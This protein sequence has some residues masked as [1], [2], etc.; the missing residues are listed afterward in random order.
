MFNKDDFLCIKRG[1]YIEKELDINTP[2]YRY[3]SYLNFLLLLANNL[4]IPL[5]KCFED[6]LEKNSFFNIFLSDLHPTD[7]LISKKEQEQSAYLHNKLQNAINTMYTSCWT[8]ETQEN[9]LMWKSYTP[10]EGGIRIESTINDFVNSINEN[11]FDIYIG[12]IKYSNC[13][14]KKDIQD[15]LF[16][17]QNYYKN[18]QEI[19]FYFKSKTLDKDKFDLPPI[20]YLKVNPEKLIKKIITSPFIKRG[21]SVKIINEL[22]SKYSYLENKI[23]YSKILI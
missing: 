17:K 23:T 14:L 1:V 18:E 9:Y 6:K 2:I 20:L 5:R 11:K 21:N 19:R 7:S 4:H 10:N 8:L 15:T 22:T 16:F 3:T 13:K 12:K